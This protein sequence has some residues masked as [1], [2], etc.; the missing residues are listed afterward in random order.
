M[1]QIMFEQTAR[2][3]IARCQ[4]PMRIADSESVDYNY[5]IKQTMHDH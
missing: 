1:L 5:F 3:T 2:A 4:L